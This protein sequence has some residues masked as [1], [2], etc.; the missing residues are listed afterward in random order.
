MKFKITRTSDRYGAQEIF[1]DFATLEELIAWAE[2]QGTGEFI[3][4]PGEVPEIEIYDDYR[5]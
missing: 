2:E 1:Q 4:I 5:E 3:L